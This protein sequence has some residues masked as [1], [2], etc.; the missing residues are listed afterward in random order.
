MVFMPPGSAK[1]TYASH[2]F[3]AHYMATHP[4]DNVLAASHSVEL[5]EDFGRKVRD[6]AE[7]HALALGVA[8]KKDNKAAHRWALTSGG[9]YFA[10]GV[11]VGIAGKRFDLAIIDD[12]IKSREAADSELVRNRIWEWYLGDVRLRMRPKGRI[13]LIQTRWHEDDLAGRLLEEMKKGGEE[14]EIVSLPAIAGPNDPLGRKPGEWLWDD[15]YGYG[16]FL[17]A[18]KDAQPPRNWS[19]LFQQEP[20]AEGGNYFKAEW[21]RPYEAGQVPALETLTIYGASDYAVTSNGGDYTVHIVVGIDPDDRMWLLDLWRGQQQADVWVN[22]WCDLVKKWHP[23]DWAEEQGQIISGVGPFLEAEANRQRAYVNREQFV[24]RASK[25]IRA[26]SIRGRMAAGGL[27]VP[28]RAPWFAD[29]RA[30]LLAFD[31]GKHDD[32]VDALG[33]VGQLLDRMIPGRVPAKDDRIKYVDTGFKP[34]E[35]LAPKAEWRT[36]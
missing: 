3:A 6:Y 36:Y 23:M 25:A 2:L 24:P 18:E 22:A 35:D 17:R 21:L 30:E 29:F 8:V 19:A 5:A 34:V 15:D 31:A 1:S 7:E 14:W 32:M 28:I 16:N 33:L 12:P 11:G 27:Y 26:Q 13:C 4:G 10:A 9:Q 20:T